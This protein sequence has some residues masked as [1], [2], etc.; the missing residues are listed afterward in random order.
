MKSK[1]IKAL[2]FL[3]ALLLLILITVSVYTQTN[4][5]R[6]FLKKA[7]EKTVSTATNQ[8][9]KIGKLEGNLLTGITIKNLTLLV[10]DEPFV[11][12]DEA[13]VKYSPLIFFD[14]PSLINRII[15]IQHIQLGTVTVTISKDEDGIWN[16]EKL[17]KKRYFKKRKSR[18]K[19]LPWSFIIDGAE[20]ENA[21]IRIIDKGKK[22]TIEFDLN[23]LDFSVNLIGLN[24]KIDLKLH[25]ADLKVVPSGA[26][27]EGLQIEG[28]YTSTISSKGKSHNFAIKNLLANYKGMAINLKGK[29]KR[30]VETEFRLSAIVSGID[31]RKGVLNLEITRAKGKFLKFADLRAD[32]NLK[33]LSSR[34]LEQPVT[35]E[36]N[37]INVDGTKI[38][39]KDG[40]IHLSSGDI[41]ISGKADLTHLFKKKGNNSFDGKIKVDNLPTSF[42]NRL[43]PRMPEG[44]ISSADLDVR[45]KWNTLT[46]YSVEVKIN[47]ILHIGDFGSAKSSGNVNWSNSR[48]SFDTIT[49]ATNINLPKILDNDKYSSLLNSNLALNGI[50][51]LGVPEKEFT[52]TVQGSLSPSKLLDELSIESG[53]YNISYK[54]SGFTINSLSLRSEEFN[55]N[56]GTGQNDKLSFNLDIKDLKV[57][58]DYS[59]IHPITGSLSASG[60]IKGPLNRPLVELR[61]EAS[62]IKYKFFKAKDVKIAGKALIDSGSPKFNLNAEFENIK[63]WGQTYK[64][65]KLTAKTKSSSLNGLVYIGEEGNWD[66]ELKFK[67][68]GLTDKNKHIEIDRLKININGQLLQN[69]ETII[70]EL[71]PE[72]VIAKSIALYFKDNYIRADADVDFNGPVEALIEINKLNM[73]DL[74]EALSFRKI[75]FG[76]IATGKLSVSGNYKNPTIVSNL[77]IQSLLFNE[78]KIEDA[79]LRLFYSKRKLKLDIDLNDKQT[80]VL[81][82]RTSANINL[83]MNN[84]K[85]SLEEATINCSVKSSGISLSPLSILN[86]EIN[87]VDGKGVIDLT[88]SG[89]LLRPKLTGVISLKEVS[90][91]PRSLRNRLIIKSGEIQLKGE[92]GYLKSLIVHSEKGQGQFEGEID[93]TDYSYK[94]K[95]KLDRIKVKPRGITAFL[96]GK[97]DILGYENKTEIKGDVKVTKAKVKLPELPSRQ[98]KEIKFVDEEEEEFYLIDSSEHDYFKERVSLDLK[99]STP[100]NVWIKGQGANIEVKGDV[101]VFKE[102]GRSMIIMGEDISIVRGTYEL[103]GKLFKLQEGKFSFRGDPEINPFLDIRA[104]HQISNVNIYVKISGTRLK[105]VIKLSSQP[106]MEESEIFSYL[107]FGTSA[108]N[109][110]PGQRAS[111]QGKVAEMV[112]F[113]AAGQIKDIVGEKF[114]LDVITFTGGQRE[115][116]ES[117][118]EVGKYVTDFLYLA[119]ERSLRQTKLS[120]NDIIQNSFKV[121]LKLFD[122]LTVESRIGG[123]D[124]G[125]DV[126]FNYSY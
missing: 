117:Q 6:N 58:N 70:L 99:L 32:V 119:Y 74:S 56:A 34:V 12:I 23:D 102:Y 25:R 8:K 41:L 9:L 39:F 123:V 85:D 37:N 50:V 7:V 11:E 65:L 110:G 62:K 72:R 81:K 19:T 87:E 96:D 36:V 21:N 45:G 49:K 113:M 16:Y 63:L 124:S 112:G 88:A 104:L 47:D 93:L 24:K 83:D 4:Y 64:S 106:S 13:K 53:D 18:T 67:L 22:K 52:V 46:D 78:L 115:F 114:G 100:G 33:L 91:Q 69:R 103:F 59:P 40:L 101:H 86:D 28:T 109:L 118:I 29:V 60:T 51:P 66:H 48:V 73:G 17:S 95:G 98:L 105:P 111:L 2:G 77:S 30:F 68:T 42:I 38:K 92:R 14:W 5:F 84:I 27:F 79:N 15:S 44:A 26:V 97:I 120:T 3:F 71:S 125:G 94:L 107:A 116:S 122:F 82:I 80:G 43:V 31:V 108:K 1:L 61:A 121:E 35:G 75:Q 89:R 76:G 54:P 20:V 57:L 55:I 90:I 10:E 126:F